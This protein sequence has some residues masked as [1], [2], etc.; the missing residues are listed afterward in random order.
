MHHPPR[1][2]QANTPPP[3]VMLRT[4]TLHRRS[5]DLMDTLLRSLRR[6]PK[7]STCTPHHNLNILTTGRVALLLCAPARTTTLMQLQGGRR[8]HL[9]IPRRRRMMMFS[10]PCQA[11]T[12]A[13]RDFSLDGERVFLVHAGVMHP[14]S[15]TCG[16]AGH[17]HS[18]LPYTQF[19]CGLEL[20]HE[21]C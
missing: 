6:P 21:P 9:T 13:Q 20:I 3:P 7:A 14:S 11:A 19:A 18:D 8:L 1:R 17:T 5:R 2:H 15:R 10:N 16:C 4:C 12:S